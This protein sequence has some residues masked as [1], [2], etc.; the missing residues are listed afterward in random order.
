MESKV[1]VPVTLKN[2]NGPK[3]IVNAA[4][5]CY[6]SQRNDS[7]LGGCIIQLNGGAA[8]AVRENLDEVDELIRKAL[9]ASAQ[10]TPAKPA[11]GGKAAK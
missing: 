1:Y 4:N 11:Q 8:I 6:L 10:G 2:S 7:S 5:V 9:A 3:V